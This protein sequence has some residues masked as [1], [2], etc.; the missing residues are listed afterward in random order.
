MT[1]EDK[2]NQIFDKTNIPAR[3]GTATAIEKIRR[4]ILK[5]IKDKSTIKDH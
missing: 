1:L 2:I 3:Q 5:L 4:E